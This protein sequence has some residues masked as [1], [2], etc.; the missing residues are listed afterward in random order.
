MKLKAICFDFDGTL[1]HSIDLLVSIF[2]QVLA[3]KQLPI[4]PGNTLRGLIGRP[5]TEI[6]Q[7]IAPSENADV[8]EKRFR[9]IEFAHNNSDEIALV[10][11][12]RPTLEFLQSRHL[13]LGIVSTKRVAVV[14]KLAR[15][16]G[17]W[18]FFAVVVGRDLVAKPKPDPEPIIFACEK[19][20]VHPREILFVGDSL[21]DLESAKNAGAPFVGVLTG[22][23]DRAEFT[24]NRADYIF[25]HVGELVNLVREINGN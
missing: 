6:F 18:D 19:I 23:C 13:K 12:T 4:P 20:G 9:E 21:L 8:L 11:E 3:E 1:V 17:I 10:A 2:K 5:L 24:K 15:E 16:L 22:V 7:E 14:E 25:G